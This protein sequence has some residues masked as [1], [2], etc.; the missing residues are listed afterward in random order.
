M[1]KDSFENDALDLS[2]V[3][4]SSSSSKSGLF[5][6]NQPFVLDLHDIKREPATE[7]VTPVS[8]A[9]KKKRRGHPVAGNK[10]GSNTS[11]SASLPTTEAAG[12]EEFYDA[13]GSFHDVAA[14]GG[15]AKPAAGLALALQQSEH[16]QDPKLNPDTT[17]RNSAT[18]REPSKTITKSV[19]PPE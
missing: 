16:N 15:Q 4:E 12:K 9:K 1:D 18:P 19:L 7:R 17:T 11:S 8:K 14:K 13:G 5:Q 2:D 3:T 6:G 10:A